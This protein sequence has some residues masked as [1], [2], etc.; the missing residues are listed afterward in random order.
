MKAP[1]GFDR[2]HL[3]L[4]A[5]HAVREEGAM[6]IGELQGVT[7]SCVERAPRLLEQSGFARRFRW[8]RGRRFRV[9]RAGDGELG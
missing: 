7:G 9:G 5:E 8:R 4:L 2:D 3:S 1:Q 6:L